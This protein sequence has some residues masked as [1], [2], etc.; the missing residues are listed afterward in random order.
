TRN[1]RQAQRMQMQKRVTDRADYA[2]NKRDDVARVVTRVVRAFAELDDELSS[3][4]DAALRRKRFP[5]EAAH[6]I[7]QRLVF[8]ATA[9]EL[10]AAL[11]Q[12][13]QQQCA[14]RIKT[15]QVAKIEFFFQAEDGIRVRTVTGVQTCALP[16]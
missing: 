13:A 7:Q 11:T 1:R 14:R 3:R 15:A 8:I 12:V 10:D 9:S 4:R 16:I 6:Q 2:A 5:V